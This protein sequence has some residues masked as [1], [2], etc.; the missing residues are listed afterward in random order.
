VKEVSE[1][2]LIPKT[3]V[4]I[5][6]FWIDQSLSSVFYAPI[7]IIGLRAWFEHE[8]I[9]I[10]WK[11]LLLGGSL[12][13]LYRWS[14]LYLL[15]A[16]PGK[17]L[18]GLRVLS[19]PE[20][21]PLGFGQSLVRVFVDQ[22]SVLLGLGPRALAFLRFDR[23]HLSDWVAETWVLQKTEET[24]RAPSSRRWV[25]ALGLCAYLSFTG[26]VQCYKVLQMSDFDLKG[27]T[28]HSTSP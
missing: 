5:F 22:F 25:L 13:F 4:R 11:W 9:F 23:R 3:R 20:K 17:M 12:R 2:Y 24:S 10:P 15:G 28:V 26:L 6:A 1:N 7:F 16:T 21:N 8:E 27:W 18:F 19:Y 14:F